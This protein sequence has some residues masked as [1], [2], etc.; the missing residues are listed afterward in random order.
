MVIL[1]PTQRTDGVYEW[2]TG[3]EIADAPAWLLELVRDD[4]DAPRERVQE[5]VYAENYGDKQQQAYELPRF[6]QRS[7]SSLTMI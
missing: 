6:K 2:I 1:P 7:M 3:V 5:Y 4:S